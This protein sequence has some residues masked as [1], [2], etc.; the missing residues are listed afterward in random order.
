MQHFKK[1]LV[2]LLCALF[3]FSMVACDKKGTNEPTD[4]GKEP[5]KVTLENIKIGFVHI[6]DPSDQGYTYNHNLGT[7]KMKKELGLKED[8]VINKFNTPE[9]QACETALRELAEQGCHIIFATSF[10][11]EDH[12]LKVAKDYP[13]IQFCHATGFQAKTSGLKNMHNY[14]GKI[15]QARYLSGIAAGLKTE[16]NLIGYVGAHPFAEVISGF[17]AFYLGAKSVNPDVKMIV[18]YTGSWNDPT[19]EEQIA[20]ALIDEG[21]DVLGQ[22][23]DST[24]PA[25]AAEAGGVFH[26]GY[27]SDMR[28]AAPKASLTSAIWDWSRYLVMAVNKV[29]AGEEIPVDWGEGLKEGVCDISPLNDAIVAPGTAEKIEEA[30][31]KIV[32][33]DWDVFTG[34]L[35]DTEGNVVVKEGET[36]MEPASAPSWDHILEGIQVPKE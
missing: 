19:K 32:A 12:V 10:G 16:K 31:A 35:V 30:R 23:C 27:N 25:T 17:T 21:C 13:N 29:V 4:P 34:P 24:A 15:Y 7:E 36:F 14:F 8:Q 33:G 20:K 11:F 5:G 28:T 22:H 26:V 9:D 3:V 2:I 18:K 6:T 1:W